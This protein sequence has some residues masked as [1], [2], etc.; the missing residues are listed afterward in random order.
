M[1]NSKIK[2]KCPD[3]KKEITV[4]VKSIQQMNERIKYLERENKRLNTFIDSD[5]LKN[6]TGNYGDIFSNIFK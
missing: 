6:M 2:I 1:I 5:R 3:C 4:N